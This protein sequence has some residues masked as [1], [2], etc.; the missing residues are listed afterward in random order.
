MFEYNPYSPEAQ[1]NPYPIWQRMRD[2]TPVH[3]NPTM[4]FYALT[5]YDDVLNAFLDNTTY[6]SGEGA[7][8]EGVDKGNGGLIQL[9]PPEH[10]IYRKLMSRVFTPR[11]VAEIEPY[12]RKVAI[13]YLDQVEGRDQFDLIQDYSLHLPLEVISELLGIP[14]EY[15]A[16]VHDLSNRSVVR[17]VSGG[18]E[19]LAGVRAATAETVAFY[20]ELVAERRQHPKDDLISNL[21]QNEITDEHGNVQPISDARVVAQFRLLA[22]AGHETIMKSIGN[23]AVALAWYPEQRAE[24]VANPALIPNAVEE[25]VRWDNPAPLEGRVVSRDVELHG[26]VIPKGSR[27]MLVMGAA[28]HDDRQYE[29]PELFSIHRDLTRP[30]TFGFGIHLCLGAALARLEMKVAF[31]ELLKRYPTFDLVE[32]GINRGAIAFFRGL[33]NLPISVA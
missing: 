10:T 8:L 22:S 19:S 17:D 12:I 27:V 14:D 20:A 15:R 13:K 26:T 24:L 25:M 32:G 2:E 1:F 9:D 11:R 3:F 33:N 18:P 4:N 29:H 6:I 31:E 16:K 30:V 28:N 7:T 23:G 5:R 21:L